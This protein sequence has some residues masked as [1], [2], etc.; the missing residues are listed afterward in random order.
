M[1]TSISL[2]ICILHPIYI[3]FDTPQHQHNYLQL[4]LPASLIHFLLLYTSFH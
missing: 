2:A 3:P 1:F 4:P